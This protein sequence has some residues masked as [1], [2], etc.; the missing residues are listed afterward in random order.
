MNKPFVIVIGLVLLASLL[1]FSMTYTVKYHEVGIKT[2]FGSAG[3]IITDPGLG[4]KWPKP[5]DSVITLD[6]RL[7]M[8]DTPRETIQ[9]ADG[10][11]LVVQAF[12]LW[13]IDTDGDGPL[14]FYSS[15]AT[16]DD[17]EESLRNEFRTA[18][19]RG[20]AN[21]R[22]N[23]LIGD[24]SQI[25]QAEAAIRQEMMNVRGKGVVP[26]TVGFRQMSLPAKTALAVV[27]RMNSERKELAGIERIKGSAE[28][29]RIRSEAQID[30]DKIR[31]FANQRAE[32]IRA[33]GD[34]EAAEYLREMS[35]DE[36]L[37]IFLVWID[38]L[39]RSLSQNTTFILEADTAPWHLINR[40][41][42]VNGN[43]IPEPSKA[44]DIDA[45]V[46]TDE[47]RRAEADEPSADN[48]ELEGSLAEKDSGNE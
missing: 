29:Q 41:A 48:G 32:E 38:A 39:E 9:T 36:E 5:V 10:Q 42:A 12:M 18:V 2:R 28:A 37:A 44:Y 13:K 14:Q 17:A 33:Q 6:T 43:G 27:N 7:Q 11:Q 40:N 19:K 30:A 4:F 21:Y 31:A 16:P 23:E 26:V 24:S 25:A 35:E 8:I 45:E 15:Y 1:L 20:V 34:A 46:A 22:F 47:T 3:A